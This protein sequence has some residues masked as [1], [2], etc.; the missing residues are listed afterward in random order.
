[1][2]WLAF[3]V[4]VWAAIDAPAFVLD[5]AGVALV[6]LGLIALALPTRRVRVVPEPVVEGELADP[7]ITGELDELVAGVVERIQGAT[8]EGAPSA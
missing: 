7:G 2:R 3:A 8:R 1:M 4:L 6:G 5:R